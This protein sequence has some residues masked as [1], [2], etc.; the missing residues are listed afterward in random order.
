MA[1]PAAKP[2]AKLAAKLAAKSGANLP[3]MSFSE[4]LDLESSPLLRLIKRAMASP[5]SYTP[6][7]L[8][9]AG[10]SSE[11]TQ[12]Q[13]TKDDLKTT[14]PA[15][16]SEKTV[17]DKDYLT[18]QKLNQVRPL[19]S[20]VQSGSSVKFSNGNVIPAVLKGSTN[21]QWLLKF[22]Q[23]L[24]QAKSIDELLQMTVAEVRQEL[25]V[26][27]VSVYRFQTEDRG[28]V[29]AESMTSGYTPSLGEALPAI[30][31]GAE[32]R[33]GYQ[34]QVVSVEN[35]SERVFS[36]YQTQLL[37]KYQIQASL[38]IPILLGQ[39]WGL[40]VVQQCSEPR[41][42]LENEV[43][44]LYQIATELRLSLQSLEFN[45]ERQSLTR[46][47]HA[48]YQAVDNASFIQEACKT[49]VQ[50]VR[51]ILNVETVAIY[52]FRPDYFGDFIYQSESKGFPSLVGSAWEDTYLKDYKGG[53]FQNNGSLVID[54]IHRSTLSSCHVATLEHFG[55]ESLAVVAIKQG[56]KLWGLL[57]AFQHSGSRRWVEDE[58]KI[59]ADMGRQL[60]VA[61]QGVGY[62]TQLE[63]QSAQMTKAAQISQAVAEIIPKIFQSQESEGIFRL[64]PQAVRS[65]LKCERAAIFRVDTDGNS[66]LMAESVS[67]GLEPMTDADLSLLYPKT[68]LLN[69]PERTHRHQKNWTV[70]NIY[71]VGHEP[72][73]IEKLEELDVKAYVITP[74]F[75]EDALWGFL[76]VYQ[77]RQAR[78]WTEFEVAAL[79]QICAQLSAAVRQVSYLEQVQHQAEQ[80]TQAAERDRLVVKI[81]ERI[82]RSLDLQQIF[83]TSAREIRNLLGVD[84]VAIY[85]FKPESNYNRGSI[86]AEDIKPGYISIQSIDIDDD[87]FGERHA[88]SYKKGR[89]FAV[90]DIYEAGLNNCYIEMLTQFQVR[91]NL[92]VPL[93]RG[94]ELWGLFCIHQ[95]SGPRHWQE[96][97]IEFA[98]QIALQLDTA[99]QQGESLEQLRK[100]S[101]QMAD[102][103]QMEKAAKE[104]LQ[105]EV[106]QILVAVRP[107]LDGDLTVRAPI[108][109]DEVGTIADAYNNTLGNL[110]R[111]V[112][113]MQKSS[114]QVALT[115]QTSEVAI[116]SLAAQA[117]QQ[118]QALDQAQKRVEAMVHSTEVVGTSAQMVEM[119]TQQANQVILVGDT[120]MDRAVE[121]ILTV[122]E[123]VTETGKRLKRL[124]ESSQK[125]SKVVNLI[126]NFTTQTQLLALNAS[127]EAT[128]AGEYGRGFSVVADEVRSL[129]RQSAN[130]A[131]EIE[132][133]V[134][135]IQMG[136]AEV[137]T[138]LET[139][140]QQVATGTELVTEAREN[141]NEIVGATGQISQ[142]V[143]SITQ[144]T[145]E[146]T[147]ECQSVK[148]TMSEVAEIANKTTEDA[149]SIS[150][151]FKELLAMAQTLQ[152]NSSQFK[153]G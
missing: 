77:S 54:D 39:V 11:E 56:E 99:I 60:G 103:A 17:T 41:Q 121:G 131:T 113:D 92:V 98:K 111:I 126:G 19:G 82:R 106:I 46:V 59:L 130:A 27:R 102:I 64:I 78:S 108:T 58:I 61:L 119:T 52:K 25:Q 110:Q 148:Q 118:F 66:A 90:A 115:S 51:Q 127:I 91:G 89:I 74:I 141:L 32:Q 33:Q 107:A 16:V 132:Q 143:A 147:Q 10:L 15:L 100:A 150:A 104:R 44:L 135:E 133:L 53:R 26:D 146:Q 140:I 105:Q 40:L 21:W 1:K 38:S 70:N 3:R 13:Q 42:W 142:L 2:A 36:P 62:L 28:T 96:T 129:A 114:L 84:R 75:M 97:E 83:K 12:Q 139:G 101:E 72:D 14:N 112:T 55:I 94:E 145:Q 67:K 63:E 57:S 123:T 71:A 109:D 73:E 151:S 124:S 24:H 144:A 93:F 76:G 47:N 152:V 45:D 88:V 49:V 120:A 137:S 128:R 138:A 81:V 8:T 23:H 65:L 79:S 153:V 136:T 22:S 37:D 43:T 20:Q 31:F 35:T 85:K 18:M 149:A 116:A 50:E 34:Q 80:F 69:I 122:R 5:N 7:N 30:A 6:S 125:I 95:C 9:N 68:N 134:Q 4:F 86:V 48:I 87:C 29:V 117:Q